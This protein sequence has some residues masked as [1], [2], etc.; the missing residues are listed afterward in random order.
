MKQ[1]LLIAS[2][3]ST[4]LILVVILQHNLSFRNNSTIVLPAGGTYLG[5]SAAPPTQNLLTGT[6]NGQKYPYSFTTPE[7]IKLVAM[8]G[9][10]DIFALAIDNQPPENNVLIGVDDLNRNDELKKY[11]KGSKRAYVESWWKQFEGLKGVSTITEFTNGKG[12]KGYKAKYINGSSEDIFFEVPDNHY[13]I[14]LANGPL[15]KNDF[16]V[17]VDSVSWEKK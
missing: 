1:T 16:D 7:S 8:G 13:V 11:I 17:I 10:F 6:I 15:P 12:L 3:I 4:I 14:H 9:A 5:P 2:G